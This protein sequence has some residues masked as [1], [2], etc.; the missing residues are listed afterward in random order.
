MLLALAESVRA[1]GPAV[2]IVAPRSPD[3]VTRQARDADF[4]VLE[5]PANDGRS[6]LA[7]LAR[8][9]RL[10]DGEVLWCN[11]MVPAMGTIGSHRRRF[12]EVHQLPTGLQRGVW[13][14]ARRGVERVFTPS[15]SMQAKVPGAEVLMNWTRDPGPLRA[16][17]LAEDEPLRV[18]FDGRFSPIN[19]LEVL[20]RSLQRLERLVDRP[21][22][23]VL[24]GNSRP[25]EHTATQRIE[26]E[27]ARVKH[28][29]RL[30]WTDSESFFE[31]VDLVV[32]PSVW[33]ESFGFVAAEAMAHCCP[34]VVS[35]VGALVE[36]VGPNHPWVARAGDPIDTARIIKV[37][38]E[39][40]S[41]ERT[42]VVANARQRWE[43]EF[44]PRAGQARVAEVLS[45]TGLL[46][47]PHFDTP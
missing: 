26:M 9:G 43:A 2:R 29:E 18:G 16:V 22:R 41:A 7:N 45:E 23:L 39:T 37:F 44:S 40:E 8:R 14:L 12:V 33:A 38:L 6:Y 17:D 30:R 46:P 20:A 3:G 19:G 4:D 28:V 27:L 47:E 15:R 42:R 34:V 10:L 13:Q 25:P 32:V 36:V 5:I 35:D 11:G 1:L 31:A 21:M 24:A